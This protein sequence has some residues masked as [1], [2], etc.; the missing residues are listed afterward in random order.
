MSTTARADV[1]AALQSVLGTYRT[2]N[3]NKLRK[4]Y[5]ARPGGT[6]DVPFAFIGNR[7]EA[8]VH[9]QG[10]RQRT[11]APTVTICDHLGDNEQSAARLDILVDG[12]VDAFTAG[13]Q[14]NPGFVLVQTAVLDGE[15]AFTG[16][17]DVTITYR[18][19]TLVFAEI[20]I[21]EGRV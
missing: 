7:D 11:F 1:V 14:V 21:A 12:L 6:G 20:V 8:I 10:V 16:P 3:P 4:I 19:A 13:V 2:A 17:S 18:A 9:T 5:T 15:E